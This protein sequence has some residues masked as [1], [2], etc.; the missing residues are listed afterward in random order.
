MHWRAVIK[1][2]QDSCKHT[3]I[4]H[5]Q[6]SCKHR[7]IILPWCTNTSSRAKLLVTSLGHGST[8]SARVES[9]CAQQ[10]KKIAL[11]LSEINPQGG[12]SA[13]QQCQSTAH[14]LSA[15]ALWSLAHAFTMFFCQ[16]HE[17]FLPKEDAKP[18]ISKSS[19]ESLV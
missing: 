18:S 8:V 3:Q 9:P 19:T 4:K 12:H 13:T 1:C 10:T 2:I 16:Q 5:T 17:V 15:M 6:N 14:P 7:H 11:L